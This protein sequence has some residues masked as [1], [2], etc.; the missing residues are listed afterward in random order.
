MSRALFSPFSVLFGSNLHLGYFFCY[1]FEGVIYFLLKKDSNI[2]VVCTF[3]R[4]FSMKFF[5]VYLLTVEHFFTF[6]VETKN[7]EGKGGKYLEKENISFV[8]EKKK[9]DGKEKYIFL[10]VFLCPL[11]S[12]EVPRDLLRSL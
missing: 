2:K 5:R 3:L 10:C 6:S 11:I 9:E 4:N 1:S 7:R 12:L 8:E